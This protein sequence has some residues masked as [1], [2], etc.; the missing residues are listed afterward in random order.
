M[1]EVFLLFIAITFHRYRPQKTRNDEALGCRDHD[2]DSIHYNSN[3]VC[4]IVL[5]RKH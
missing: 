4:L 2:D 5:A 3:I 1:N